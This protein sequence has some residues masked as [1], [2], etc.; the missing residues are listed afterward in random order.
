MKGICFTGFWNSAWGIRGSLS[1]LYVMQDY[2]RTSSFKRSVESLDFTQV[3]LQVAAEFVSSLAKRVEEEKAAG[4]RICVRAST[5]CGAY[6][7]V[8][9]HGSHLAQQS[10]GRSGLE[11]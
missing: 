5:S 6:S 10:N 9:T 7:A 1:S 3:N 4:K 2:A 8:A 11:S